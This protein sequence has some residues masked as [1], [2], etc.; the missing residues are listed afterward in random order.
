MTG[1]NRRLEMQELTF[2]ECETVEGGI[3]NTIT[4]AGWVIQGAQALLSANSDT[5]G[6]RNMSDLNAA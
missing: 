3:M 2:E 5:L 1:D 4:I 6:I